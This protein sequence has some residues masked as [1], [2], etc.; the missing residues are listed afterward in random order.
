[1]KYWKNKKE[2]DSSD[3]QEDSGSA[4]EDIY[5]EFNK[6]MA[7]IVNGRPAPSAIISHEDNSHT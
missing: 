3:D 1:M 4:P 5:G 7:P 2:D 6:K